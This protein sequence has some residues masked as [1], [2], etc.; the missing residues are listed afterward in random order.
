[1]VVGILF[2]VSMLPCTVSFKVAF[3][4]GGGWNNCGH[5]TTTETQLIIPRRFYVGQR[6]PYGNS[7][8]RSIVAIRGIV[9]TIPSLRDSNCKSVSKASERTRWTPAYPASNTCNSSC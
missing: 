4:S 1:M 3:S 2:S 5:R 9:T 8:S 6:E 7:I